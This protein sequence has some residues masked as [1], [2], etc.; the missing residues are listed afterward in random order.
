M[1]DKY[2]YSKVN[3]H[4]C[5]CI[6]PTSLAP[7]PIASVTAVES[8]RRTRD[9]S[10]AFCSGDIRQQMTALDDDNNSSRSLRQSY[11][12]PYL[13]VCITVTCVTML[14]HKHDKTNIINITLTDNGNNQIRPVLRSP[15]WS[16]CHTTNAYK[17]ILNHLTQICSINWNYFCLLLL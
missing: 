15:Q 11:V 13:S 8:W 3:L 7:S 14:P 17:T 16:Y 9:T 4:Y 5:T 6:M 10:S 2:S 12:R 1:R